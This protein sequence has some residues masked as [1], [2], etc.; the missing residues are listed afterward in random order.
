VDR[1]AARWSRSVSSILE[2]PLRVA[3][4]KN[5]MT[6][7]PLVAVAAALDALSGLAEQA[8][9]SARQVLAAAVTVLADPGA[10]DLVEAL[11]Q[12]AEHEAL[13]PLGRL[14]RRRSRGE[15]VPEPPDVD[16][17][18]LATARSG[19]V[20]TLGERRALARRPSR[21]AFDKLL[22]DPHPMVVENLLQ[23]PRMTEDDVVRMVARRPAYPDVIGAVAR[24]PTWSQRA[25]VRMAIIQNPGAPPE[26]AVPMVRLL[27]RPEL[28]QV[29]AAAD[30]P[31][32]VRAAAT[33][34]L[35]RRPPVPERRDGGEPQ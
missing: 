26:L 23:N 2:L 22:L 27:I 13:L 24:H 17:R 30:I 31:A 29:V 33:E 5:E 35:E 3:Y 28:Q 21:A 34:L 4:L 10:A 1:L 14:L 16:E 11:R 15:P 6:E 8:D 18:R 9:P 20:L 25:R 19:R 32:V 7:R 12:L